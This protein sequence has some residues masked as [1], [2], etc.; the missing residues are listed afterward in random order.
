MTAR[1]GKGAQPLE[2]VAARM[3][4]AQSLLDG[5][6]RLQKMMQAGVPGKMQDV[7][8]ARLERQAARLQAGVRRP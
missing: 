4:E 5:M 1:D 8:L 2:R 3:A 7:L 6:L